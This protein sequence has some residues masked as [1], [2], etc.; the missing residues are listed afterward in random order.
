MFLHVT[1]YSNSLSELKI[2]F[3]INCIIL[4]DCKINVSTVCSKKDNIQLLFVQI[5]ITWLFTY[6]VLQGDVEILAKRTKPQINIL[7]RKR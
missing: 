7:L 2:T 6:F 3:H 5:T 1:V 4:G